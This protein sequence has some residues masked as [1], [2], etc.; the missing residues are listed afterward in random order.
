MQGLFTKII[1]GEIPSR[2]LW[3]DDVCVSF[4][5][6]RPLAQGHAL[7]VPRAAIDLWTDLDV[8]TAT[9]LMA[10][11][12]SIGQAQMQ[13]FSPT[14]IG[15]MIAGFEVPHTHVHVVPIDSMDHLDFAKADPAA[16][17]AVLDQQLSDLRSALAAAGHSEVSSR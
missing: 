10:V 2:M 12:H 13:I 17:P 6:V 3:E 4:L 7:V 8:E 14:R 11:A 1:D 15:L 9:H 5:D 16:D